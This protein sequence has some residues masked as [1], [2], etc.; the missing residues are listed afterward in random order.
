LRIL[1]ILEKGGPRGFLSHTLCY[2]NVNSRGKNAFNG[3]EKRIVLLSPGQI[4]LLPQDAVAF[5]V[6]SGVHFHPSYFL[7]PG[8]D[9]LFRILPGEHLPELLVEQGG[10]VSVSRRVKIFHPISTGILTVS[11]K[12]S[13]GERED[14]S[15]PA[16]AALVRR[17]GA[18]VDA[19]LTVPDEEEAITGVL[20]E[21]SDKKRFHLILATGGTG[22][23]RRDVTPEAL[24]KVAEK[25]V[26]GIGEAMRSASMRITP[27]AVLSRGGAVIR[28]ETLILALPGS[29]RAASE[30]FSVIAPAL[31]HGIEI[32][33]GWDSECGS[34]HVR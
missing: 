15:G 8:E 24:A 27:K 16:L 25:D 14:T 29:E 2:V 18:T 31:R 30:C 20:T 4:S 22:F 17:L 5:V 12:G 21:W 1:D 28:G 13:R 26:P 33:C 19:M 3:M 10:F 7:S 34:R 11:D 32:L 23:S 6:S 9:V